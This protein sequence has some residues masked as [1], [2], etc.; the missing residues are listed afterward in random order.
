MERVH[1]RRQAETRDA[2]LAPMQRGRGEPEAR[3]SPRPPPQ[4][5]LAQRK[6]RGQEQGE[7]Y[8]QRKPRKTPLYGRTS[9]VCPWGI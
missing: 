2:Q 8:L 7:S 6:A 3:G 4:Q 9:P 5:R 1:F